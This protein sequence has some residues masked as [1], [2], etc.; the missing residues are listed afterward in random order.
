MHG[1]TNCETDRLLLDAAVDSDAKKKSLQ[2]CK[3]TK[4]SMSA[5]AH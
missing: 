3:L 4:S 2:C 5:K 1:A